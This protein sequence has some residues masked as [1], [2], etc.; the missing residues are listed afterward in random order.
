[1]ARFQGSDGHFAAARTRQLWRR[2]R[3][4]TNSKLAI[5]HK[6]RRTRARYVV[7]MQNVS[8]RQ[9]GVVLPASSFKVT[10]AHRRIHSSGKGNRSTSCAF[11]SP[12][13]CISILQGVY[14]A[15]LGLINARTGMHTVMR[16]PGEVKFFAAARGGPRV[17]MPEPKHFTAR[18]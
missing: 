16:T 10:C 9:A 3:G 13:V 1:M 14:G 8:V 7:I 12:C 11:T 5:A 6:A 17:R 18:A 2:A 4:G 15:L